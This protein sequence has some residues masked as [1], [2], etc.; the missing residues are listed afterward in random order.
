MNIW[1]KATLFSLFF[2]VNQLAAEDYFWVGGA[3]DWSDISHWATTSG[4][5]IKYD[6][7]PSADDNV[8]FDANSFTGP[9]QVINLN[10]DN[11]F[12]LNMD[13]TGA[14]GNPIF[15]GTETQLLNIY[16]SLQL[17][18][19]MTFDFAGEVLFRS[20]LP[21]AAIQTAG[22]KLGKSVYFDGSGGWQLQGELEVDSIFQ[23]LNGTVATAGQEVRGK[24]CYVTIQNSGS[25]NLSDSRMIFTGKPFTGTNINDFFPT[26]WIKNTGTFNMPANTATLDLTD[27]TAAFKAD[28]ASYFSRLTFSHPNG[29]VS[30]DLVGTS[31]TNFDELTFN[32]SADISNTFT[33]G[34]LIL[35]AGRSYNFG[36]GATYNIGMLTANGTCVAPIYILGR[37]GVGQATFNSDGQSIV[38]DFV[39]L[40]NIR[41]SGTSSFTADNSADLGNNAGWVINEKT[42]NDL[43]WVGGSGNWEDPMHW[44]FSS[45]GPGGACVPSGADNVHFDGNSFTAAGQTVI[46]NSENIYCK[47]MTWL[48]ATG[49]PS[50]DGIDELAMHILGSLTFIPAM[51]LEFGGTFHFEAS[52]PGQTIT[53]GNLFF[54]GEV[55]F[56]GAG[57]EWTLQDNLAVNLSIYLQ[58]GSL[59]TND[60]YVESY[61]LNALD[62]S[63]RKLAL[64]NSTWVLKT[65][66]NRWPLWRMQSQN[67]EFDA[68][69]ST[70]HFID[71]AGS[72]E[73]AGPNKLD[74]HKVIFSANFSGIYSWDNPAVHYFDSLIY[75]A[76]GGI[77]SD[78]H[79]GNLILTPGY[80]YEFSQASMQEIDNLVA[81]ATCAAPIVLQSYLV[82]QEAF[83]R[84]A[85]DHNDLQHLIVQDIHI[86]GTGSF[87]ALQSVDL[88]NNDGWV[89]DEVTGRTLYWVGD[90]G[91]WEDTVHWSLSSGGTGGECIPTPIDDVIFDENSFQN[92]N[93]F[94]TA[95][96]TDYYYCR[97]MIWRT[98]NVTPTLNLGR[99]YAYGN[100][101]LQEDMNVS[102]GITYM[103]GDSTHA[104]YSKGHMLSTLVA[105]GPG[106]YHLADDFEA[107]NLW[108]FNGRFFT[109]NNDIE[110]VEMSVGN[111]LNPVSIFLGDSYI[112]ITGPRYTDFAFPFRT[113]ANRGV[114]IDPGNSVMELTNEQSGI[115]TAG[116]IA[117][118]NVLFSAIEGESVI[119]HYY[120]DPIDPP[121]LFNRVE[122]NNDGLIEGYNNMDSLVFAA[123]KSY[124]LEPGLSQDV[125]EYLQVLGNNCN[126]IELKSVVPGEQAIINMP[127]AGI[128]LG[129]FIQMQ[130]QSGIGGANFFAGSHSVDIGTSNSGWNFDNRPGFQEVGFLG[131]DQVL[132]NGEA[133]DLSAYS[134]SP[135]EQY[136]WSNGSTEAVIPVD[137]PGSFWARVTFGN[138]C[139]IIDTI[140]VTAAEDF[141]VDLG[142]DTTLCNGNDLVLDATNGLAGLVYE[143]QDGSIEPTFTLDAPGQYSV[144]LMLSNCSIEDTVIVDYTAPPSVDLGTD[145]ELCEGENTILEAGMATGQS[146]VWQD[147][148]ADAQFEASISGSYHVEVSNGACSVSDSI[149]LT[150][151]PLPMIDLGPDTTICEGEKVDFDLS[152]RAEQFLWQDGATTP[153]YSI[154]DGGSFSVALTENGCMASDTINVEILLNPAPDLGPD[155]T[156]CIGES[157]LLEAGLPTADSYLWQDGSVAAT[158]EVQQT[159]FYTL[160][161][162]VDGCSA[163]DEVFIDF[164]EPPQ[165]SLGQDSSICSG[166]VLSFDF[167]AI[168]DGFLWQDGST[169]AQY[170]ISEAGDYE[171]TIEKSGCTATAGVRISLKPLP[172][173]N[174]GPDQTLCE[175]EVLLLETTGLADSY[176][177]Q[178]GSANRNLPVTQTGSYSIRGILDG[179][180][181]RDTIN[182]TFL[183]YPEVNFERQL[184]ACEGDVV[185][186][187]ASAIDAVYRWQDGTTQPILEVM[188]DGDYSVEVDREGCIT[189]ASTRVVF[190]ARPTVNI[191]SDA[192]LCE[193]ESF[194]IKGEIQ[195]FDDFYWSDGSIGE[196]LTVTEN[197][198]YWLEAALGNCLSAD[199][200][201][202]TFQVPPALDLGPDQT[203]CQGETVQ[204]ISN[205]DVGIFTWQDSS[206]QTSLV[207]A[208]AGTYWLRLDDGICVVVDSLDVFVSSCGNLRVAA[209][210]VFSPNGD[211]FN[212]FFTVMPDPA[213]EIL[214]FNMHIYDRWGNRI[215]QG[216]NIDTGWDGSALDGPAHSATYVFMIQ[217]RYRD[218]TD[219]FTRTVSGDVLLL[220]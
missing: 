181:A 211:G 101:E 198:N 86:N 139:E 105:D 210:N 107:Y 31:E 100:I 15:R 155:R 199:T 191:G 71:H 12:C 43:F 87:S 74:F 123:G 89:F 33:T 54:L 203:I 106:E 183:P 169:S 73:I 103:R 172:E 220:R 129:D 25:L 158:L 152:G 182:V 127:A 136:E 201:S 204:L 112:T 98:Q 134:Y 96:A 135:G 146:Y 88:G 57:G 122:F 44:S 116:G 141:V 63:P 178:D 24:Y 18:T 190:G 7:L 40:K 119:R 94:V 212:D 92:T 126:S 64:G 216:S 34:S 47:D 209:P 8:F 176:N 76:A 58:N 130:D 37:T 9:N 97:N 42:N 17:I 85:N 81:P 159:G 171:L 68:G 150:F 124:R 50:L 200:V 140:T 78:F 114:T 128:V 202:I 67:L 179:C 170:S 4:G 196:N 188:S 66:D 117:L 23:L 154:V 160:S 156:A 3:G 115:L 21:D 189:T 120:N 185:T 46:L 82:G 168:G 38:V 93:Q 184:G 84:S 194:V 51:Q 49:N 80:T 79:I 55:I 151:F 22:H 173:V 110:V 5:T 65:K 90:G 83:I 16:G 138:N 69:T 104:L 132:C 214:E 109:D 118:N 99:L 75:E 125:D 186:L 95:Y 45:G 30:L 77:N 137:N 53:S 35:S 52:E 165:F 91:E 197:G 207:A 163:T 62:G 102:M 61:E 2:L 48:G 111:Y 26:V 147:G 113:L 10:I 219:E 70:I 6:A 149:T 36:G 143:W 27:R 175:G 162:S 72:V 121:A 177:W 153:T 161:V 217:I 60:Q 11:I 142:P 213:Y 29:R 14:T 56:D 174:L 218:Q 20:A 167:G 19:I 192:H 206:T 144:R 148:S 59:I 39:N 195:N 193:G 32:G 157:L 1:K 164:I 13:W 133:I 166:D 180:S 131:A 205:L 41:T 28:K 215:Y 208:E 108:L 187:D 145:Q